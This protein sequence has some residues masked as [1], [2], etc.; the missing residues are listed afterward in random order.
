MASTKQS[1]TDVV[2]SPWY[3]SR[4][5]WGAIATG[6]AGA[7]IYAFPDNSELIITLMTIGFGMA[8]IT[9][10]VWSWARPK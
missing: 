2:P 1:V 7:M 6:C 4:R 10:P 5:L 9:L 8:G 3:M